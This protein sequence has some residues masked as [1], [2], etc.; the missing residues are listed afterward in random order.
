MSSPCSL[1]ITQI[2]AASVSFGV[3]CVLDWLLKSEK[4]TK[5]QQL[6]ILDTIG[7]KNK[8]RSEVSLGLDIKIPPPLTI[9]HLTRQVTFNDITE[10]DMHYLSDLLQRMDIMTGG[11]TNTLLKYPYRFFI[12]APDLTNDVIKE[13]Y[14]IALASIYSKRK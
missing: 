3:E 7:R 2:P 5:D 6:E 10:L 8:P 14:E 1:P 9:S 12:M 13:G 4:I 11:E